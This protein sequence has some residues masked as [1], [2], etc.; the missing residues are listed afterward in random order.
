MAQFV[1]CVLHSVL[2]NEH[3][4]LDA[5]GFPKLLQDLLRRDARL[6]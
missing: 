4:L 1:S 3:H 6:S 2:Q 5:W